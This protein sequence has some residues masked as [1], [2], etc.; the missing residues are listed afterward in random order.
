MK[1][2]IDLIQV[3]FFALPIGATFIH[4]DNFYC[5][6]GNNEVV[7]L[8]S[9][10]KYLFEEHYGCLITKTQFLEFNLKDE[11]IRG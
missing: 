1:Y 3:F 9:G 10:N 6:I 5:R 11:V 8:P 7:I 2:E 4:K